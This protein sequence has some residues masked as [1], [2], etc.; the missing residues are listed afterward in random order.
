MEWNLQMNPNKTV[1]RDSS[2]LN[3]RRR[4]E[5][6]GAGQGLR[7]LH[8]FPHLTPNILSI[9]LWGSQMVYDQPII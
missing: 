2:L 8:P 4:C 6:G 9:W 3:T 7:A 1:W 5:G